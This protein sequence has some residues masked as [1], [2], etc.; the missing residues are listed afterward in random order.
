MK[1][2][3]ENSIAGVW[4]LVS[5]Q[6]PLPDGTIVSGEDEW[7]MMKIVTKSHFMFVEQ[8]PDRPKFKT[9]GGDEELLAAAKGFFGGYG[10]YTFDGTTYTEHIKIFLNPNYVDTT[11]TYSCRFQ[12]GLWIQTG[13]FPMKSVGLKEDDYEL[14]EVWRRVE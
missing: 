9:G 14:C 10:T 2:T 1:S 8:E 11:I 7:Q 3:E 5:T 4:E 12:D 6:P 13:L